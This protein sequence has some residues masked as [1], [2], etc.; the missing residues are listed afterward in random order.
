MAHDALE[1]VTAQLNAATTFVAVF[2]AL[3]AGDL[4]VR[5]QALK[6]SFHFLARTVHPD[7][8]PGYEREASATFQILNDLHQKAEEALERGMYESSFASLTASVFDGI[9]LESAL[10]SYRLSS[11][12]F[13]EGDFSMIYRASAHSSK[14]NVL[15]KISH[16]PSLNRWLEREAMILARFRDAKPGSAIAHVGAYVPR[17]IDTFLIEGP[18]RTRFRVNVMSSSKGFVSVGEVI[19]AYPH[20]L[21]PAQVAWVARRIIAQALAA[22]LIGTV[23]GALTPDHV[24]VNPVTHE[25]LHIGWAHAIEGSGG[26]RITHVVDRFRDFYPPEVFEKK[27]PDL[28]SDLFMAGKTIIRLLGGDVQRNTLPSVVPKELRHL[29]LQLIEKSPSRRPSDGAKYLNEFTR[30]VRGIWG[31]VYRPLDMP[32]Q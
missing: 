14:A 27:V 10:D 29:V 5:K 8:V 24:L 25:P 13:R 9:E 30:V 7:N 1:A 31:K 21:V 11:L 26:G 22:S 20:G 15:V 18:G 3:P 2:G 6:R 4:K 19:A 16:E 17:L 28:R 12:P 32:I 23:H